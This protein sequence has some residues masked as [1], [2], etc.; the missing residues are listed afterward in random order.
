MTD[1]YPFGAD[2]LIIP[3]TFV[4]GS[5]NRRRSSGMSRMRPAGE[6]FRY[7]AVNSWVGRPIRTETYG[8]KR[9]H[10]RDPGDFGRKQADFVL[11]SA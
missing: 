9:E 2:T 4:G 3:F 5:M 1:R 10:G 7:G 6:L 8:K 11:I